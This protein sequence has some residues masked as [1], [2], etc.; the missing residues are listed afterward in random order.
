MLNLKR[1]K[2][3]TLETVLEGCEETLPKELLSN[4]KLDNIKKDESRVIEGLDQRGIEE[5]FSGRDRL[6]E[7]SEKLK[8][9]GRYLRM[10]EKKR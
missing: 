3:E 2:K 8:T 10:R 5:D 1:G 4:K 7:V 9:D 6:N